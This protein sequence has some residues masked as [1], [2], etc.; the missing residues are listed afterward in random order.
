MGATYQY[1]SYGKYI[2]SSKFYYPNSI[3]TTKWETGETSVDEWKGGKVCRTLYKGPIKDF[4]LVIEV[5]DG[6]I[7]RVKVNAKIERLHKALKDTT[8]NPATRKKFLDE[9]CE[10]NQ[11]RIVLE[12]QE[13]GERE[14]T[15]NRRPSPE[16][17]YGRKWYGGKNIH[18]DPEIPGYHDVK[19]KRTK[20]FMLK[21]PLPEFGPEKPQPLSPSWDGYANPP[22]W[23]GYDKTPDYKGYKTE[24]T[25]F[26]VSLPSESYIEKFKLL[27]F[28]GPDK[29]LETFA[30][31]I[32]YLESERVRKCNIKSDLETEYVGKYARQPDVYKYHRGSPVTHAEYLGEFHRNVKREDHLNFGAYGKLGQQKPIG[33]KGQSNRTPKMGLA[34][35]QRYFDSRANGTLTAI[36]ESSYKVIREKPDH[37]DNEAAPAF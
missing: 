1:N 8:L 16:I 37:D 35:F 19:W 27:K 3:G 20:S 2:S 29:A 36:P 9:L 7:S 23:D 6:V 28:V 30:E 15:S 14:G 25:L 34:S 13:S 24:K 32:D 12:L 26:R 18:A 4:N 11:Y 17:P 5:G 31:Y 10:G 33:P 21:H 22:T